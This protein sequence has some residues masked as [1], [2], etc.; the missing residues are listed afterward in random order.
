MSCYSVLAMQTRLVFRTRCNTFTQ[1]PRGQ[2]MTG[3]LS[4]RKFLNFKGM[5]G[6]PRY[7][8]QGVKIFASRHLHNIDQASTGPW[9][10]GWLWSTNLIINT[11]RKKREQSYGQPDGSPRRVI[12]ALFF[13]QCRVNM[14]HGYSQTVNVTSF[15]S[16]NR[17]HNS[18]MLLDPWMSP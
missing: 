17:S 13:S 8:V 16:K 6:V 9:V 18:V 10:N 14:R 5:S 7:T 15:Y 12:F 11:L 4:M 3:Q 2:K 1:F